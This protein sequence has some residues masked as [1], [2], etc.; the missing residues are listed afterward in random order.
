MPCQ[1]GASFNANMNI[2]NKEGKIAYDHVTKD[3][4]KKG[5]RYY[6]DCNKLPDGIYH[7]NDFT[8]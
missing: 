2:Q 1:N 7:I 3:N 6:F 4:I 8:Q 5:Y